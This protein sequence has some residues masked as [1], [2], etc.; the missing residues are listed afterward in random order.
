MVDSDS[1]RLPYFNAS[2]AEVRRLCRAG[3]SGPVT[4]GMAAGYIQANIV[5]LPASLADAFHE[6]CLRN[7]KPCPLVGMSRPGDYRLPSLGA[8]LDLRTDLPLYRVW[9]DGNMVAETGD[10]RDQW[11]DDLVTFALGCSFSFENALTACDV[12]MRHLQLGRGVPVYRTNIACTPVGPFAGPVVVS[13][14]PFRSHHAIRAVQI[15]SLIPLA[16]GAPIQ[17]GF[18]E[19]IG[20]ADIDSPD[21]GDPTEVADD[22]LPVF[23]ACGVTPQAVLAASKPEF[24]ITH[25]P[26]AMLVTDMP[27]EGYEDLVASHRGRII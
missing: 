5:M 14:R 11:R 8:D 22:E 2:P 6:F 16:H 10:I 26:G 25:A 27:I 9:R 15:S 24:A 7:P 17:I 20:I 3:E 21:Y 19:E 1:A 12:P 18:P 4:A 23:W 13:M